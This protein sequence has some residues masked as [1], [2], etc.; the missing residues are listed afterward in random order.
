[1]DIFIYHDTYVTEK[2]SG[3]AKMLGAFRATFSISKRYTK[4]E[5]CL[6]SG[7]F[8]KTLS[9]VKVYQKR[10]MYGKGTVKEIL[11]GQFEKDFFHY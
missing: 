1:M 3:K 8:R 10:N 6:E 7:G 5:M 2:G 11:F 4:T 9:L